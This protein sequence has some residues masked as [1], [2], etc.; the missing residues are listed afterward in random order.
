MLA[1]RDCLEPVHGRFLTMKN[2]ERRKDTPLVLV[3]WEDSTQPIP[4]WQYLSEWEPST[5]LK[6]AS[7]GWLIEDSET[8]TLAPNLGHLNDDEA[9]QASGVIRIPARAVTRI[10]RLR[11][12]KG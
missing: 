12:R 5:P 3:E 4:G 9:V 11:E 2:A 10:V 7:V 8:K 6:C 1:T